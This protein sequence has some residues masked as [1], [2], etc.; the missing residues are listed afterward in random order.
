MG[1]MHQRVRIAVEESITLTESAGDR[2]AC[3]AT[4]GDC[5]QSFQLNENFMCLHH[6]VQTLYLLIRF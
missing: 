5:F 4:G 1:L 3:F 6:F 2:T